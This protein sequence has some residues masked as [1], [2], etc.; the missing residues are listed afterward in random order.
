MS[1]ILER[2]PNLNL[3]FLPYIPKSLIQQRQNVPPFPIHLPHKHSITTT[4]FIS[5]SYPQTLPILPHNHS[6][7]IPIPFFF[8]L[9]LLILIFFQCQRLSHWRLRFRAPAH[10]IQQISCR[11]QDH[12][13]FTI[14][15]C[16]IW[17]CIENQFTK[18]RY[19]ISSR[20]YFATQR[21]YLC[22]KFAII[23]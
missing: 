9:L 3:L 20:L 7:T 19:P 2:N 18:V 10:R 14:G 12:G 8:F 4:L 23:S 17:K 21:Y 11:A 22:L 15:A 6:Q 5:S 1:S 16:S 13:S